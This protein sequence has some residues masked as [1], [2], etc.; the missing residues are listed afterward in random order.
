MQ[1]SPAITFRTVGGVL[2]FYFFMGPTPA[3]VVRQYLNAVGKPAM[4]PLW[5]LGF[6][7]CRFG[8]KTLDKC[9]EVM[10]RNLDAGIPLVR[11]FQFEIKIFW[12]INYRF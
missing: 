11:I 3:D 12:S 9:K 1:E 8:Y 10:K 2:D 6:H 4:P 5:G 7:L